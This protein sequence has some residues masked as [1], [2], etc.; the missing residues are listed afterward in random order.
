MPKFS[1]LLPTRGRPQKV[2]QFLQ[3][4]IQQTA[5]L[6]DI[7]VVL[8]LDE[9]DPESHDLSCEEIHLVKIIGPRMSMG[10]YNTACLQR[11]SGEIVILMNDDVLVRTQGWDRVI[12]GLTESTPDGIFLASVNDLQVG[13]TWGTFPVLSR[14]AC[15][16]MSK[17]YPDEYQGWFIDLHV[18]D[19][20]KRVRHLGHDRIFNFPQVIFEHLHP[21][22][23]KAE[24]DE[25]YQARSR[26]ADDW[27]FV[28]LR[29]LRRAT[30][31][32]LHAA[33]LGKQLPELPRHSGL[34]SRPKW[35]LRV[36]LLY[37]CA[38]LLDITLSLRERI[39]LF[40]WMTS[41]YLR[42]VG[43]LPQKY[44]LRVADEFHCDTD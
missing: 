13:R 15:K 7:E 17:P 8:Y 33:I 19:V 39:H 37:A 12:A 34:P 32:R 10:A 4:L 23:G 24:L 31:Y 41:R 9:D 20:F 28:S 18:F 6:D 40:F 14:K 26:Y 38:F 43:Y 3:S 25:T 30:A 42:S 1:F 44:P 16:V 11:S 36:L 35:V 5:N 21:D 2:R 29:D 22:A 27:V